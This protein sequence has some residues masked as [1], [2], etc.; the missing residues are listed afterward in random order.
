MELDKDLWEL[1][2]K[3]QMEHSCWIDGDI[4]EDDRIESV[5]IWTQDGHMISLTKFKFE[6]VE[7]EA[8]KEDLDERQQE[9]WWLLEALKL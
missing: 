7:P 2:T 4:E 5:M 1:A 3:L 8:K 6:E 9:I